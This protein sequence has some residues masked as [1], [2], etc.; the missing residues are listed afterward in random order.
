MSH[1]MKIYELVQYDAQEGVMLTWHVSRAKA[2]R[3]RKDRL[4]ADPYLY[5]DNFNIHEHE[6]ERSKEALCAWLTLHFDRN[7]R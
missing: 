4:K 6:I 5:P 2:E 1:A 7:N 3:A